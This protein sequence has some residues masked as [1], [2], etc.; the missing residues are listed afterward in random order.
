MLVC[1]D[2]DRLLDEEFGRVST[3]RRFHI[4]GFS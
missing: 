3:F 1:N 2:V 4:S